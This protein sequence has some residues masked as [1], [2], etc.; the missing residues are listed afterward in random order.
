MVLIFHKEQLAARASVTQF[1]VQRYES[2]A[3]ARGV[4]RPGPRPKCSGG[5]EVRRRRTDARGRQTSHTE[6]KTRPPLLAQNKSICYPSPLHL[7]V[8]METG[9]PGE[10]FQTG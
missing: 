4:S 3:H 7:T 5:K 1:P 8:A 2:R 6:H 9:R 10:G